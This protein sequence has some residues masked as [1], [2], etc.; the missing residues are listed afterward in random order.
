MR[1][2]PLYKN[3][4]NGLRIRGVKTD[5][6]SKIIPVVPSDTVLRVN[7]FNTSSDSAILSIL[8]TFE[9]TLKRLNSDVMSNL[10]DPSKSTACIKTFQRFRYSQYYI[11]LMF[12][13]RY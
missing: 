9:T 4:S 5:E 6:A 12:N 3:P 7:N 2:K 8:S 10:A 13:L 1:K 11:T